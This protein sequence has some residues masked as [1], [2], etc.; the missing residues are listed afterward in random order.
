[1]LCVPTAG[2]CGGNF[3][4]MNEMNILTD[5]EILAA[6]TPDAVEGDYY[7]PQN[8]ARAIEAAVL[9][10]LAAKDVKPTAYITYK[11]H[12]LHADDP[13][14]LEH[15]EP[16][17]LYT[18]TQLLAAQQRTAEACANVHDA[19]IERLRQQLAAS[20]LQI[21]RLREVLR[22][23]FINWIW[24]QYQETYTPKDTDF[25]QHE[26]GVFLDDVAAA[27]ALPKDITALEAMIQKAGEVMRQR[28][29]KVAFDIEPNANG[30]IEAAI[31]ALPGVTLE[32][33]K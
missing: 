18:E 11:G 14:V 10:K 13:K 16:E 21:Q 29:M 27:L 23:P 33:L 24:H 25:P 2:G 31:S 7:L 8:F 22:H 26:S 20:Q 32:D 3:I 12:L 17:P 30:P 4:G 28:S 15:S 19:T 5:D 9:A 6:M 1:M